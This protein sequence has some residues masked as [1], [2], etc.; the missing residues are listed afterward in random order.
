[1]SETIPCET[2]GAPT[3]MTGTKRCDRCWEVERRLG[4]YASTGRAARAFLSAA[5]DEGYGVGVPGLIARECS[6]LRDLLLA[7]NE[8]YGNSVL[9]PLRLFSRADT[10]EQIRVRLD[11]KLSRLARGSGVEDEDVVLDFIGYLVFLRIA[12]RLQPARDADSDRDTQ[13]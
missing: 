8:K 4:A 12:Q 1:M 5:L 2:C 9:D 3:A 6:A 13:G 7:K 11:D 10:V